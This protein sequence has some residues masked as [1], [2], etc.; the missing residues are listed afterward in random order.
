MYPFF[1][2]IKKTEKANYPGSEDVFKL[3]SNYVDFEA[4]KKWTEEFV[5]FIDIPTEDDQWLVDI[6]KKIRLD[7]SHY[8]DLID[9]YEGR[10]GIYQLIG[11]F[12]NQDDDLEKIPKNIFGSFLTYEKKLLYGT[13]V[14][15]KTELP[16]TDYSAKVTDVTIEDL[17][18]L[19]MNNYYHSCV[20]IGVDRKIEQMFFDNTRHFVDH[21]FNFNR[22]NTEHLLK[23]EEF[24][25]IENRLLKFNL[26]FI[27]NGKDDDQP[28]NEP[29]TRL[30]KRIVKGDGVITSPISR[31][32]ADIATESNNESELRRANTSF[33]GET[34]YDISKQDI[35]DLLK[36]ENML[37]VDED[38]IKEETNEK[39]IRIIK[40]K[41]RI[42]NNKLKKL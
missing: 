27:Y 9:C 5:E 4:L 25:V 14:L 6:I 30:L 31:S 22:S 41:Y 18:S 8:G 13:L 36:V 19:I 23:N 2:D 28:V 7:T 21:T 20:R 42:L 29:M 11:C 17:S 38:D 32:E 15:F 16:S 1:K 26:N 35:I 12:P 40:N 10:D 37:Y 3:K 34:F 24:G 39:G 33:S